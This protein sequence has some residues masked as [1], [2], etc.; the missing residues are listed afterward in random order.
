MTAR[1]AVLLLAVAAVVIAASQNPATAV[2]LTAFAV[3]IIAVVA[4][5]DGIE[6]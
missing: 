3:S 6:D 2:V 5:F 4:W 1:N